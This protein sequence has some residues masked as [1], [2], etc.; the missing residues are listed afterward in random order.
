MTM[1]RRD[2]LT[3]ALAVGAAG[4]SGSAFGAAPSA[5]AAPDPAGQAARHRRNR[6]A[7]STYSFW[8]FRPD[9]K[10]SIEECIR[11]ASAM[12]FDGVEV[13]HRQMDGEE[14]SYV[15]SLKRT[16]LV[17]GVDLC[18]LSI[19]QGFLYPDAEQRKKN[20][21]H[22]IR[23]IELAYQLGIPT[24][25]V[26][27]GRWG[28]SK[29]FDELMKRRG[30]EDRLP[31]VSDDQAFAWVI[32]AFR[33]CIPK[34]RECGVVLGLENHWGLALTP[35]G[36]L[37]I[38]N[39]V[40]SPWLGVTM[41][42]GNFLEDPYDRLEKIAPK[43]VYVHAKTYYGGGIWYALDLDYDRIARLL[44]QNNYHG[45]VSLE[46]EGKEDW[47]TAIPKSLALLRKAFTP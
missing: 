11:Q 21:E 2:L 19:H 45:Y 17:E 16:A 47:R 20:V 22:T 36:L 23:C 13:L 35:E 3:S 12:G 44:R 7:V 46:F 41:D 5:E 25:R 9:S 26:N 8:R 14:R 33:Q 4:L 1:H 10:L 31:G 37:R 6:V 28:T 18:G 32:D 30:I 34:A 29:S 15:Q 42:T 39:A 40:D 27:T 24:V 38:V 43:A